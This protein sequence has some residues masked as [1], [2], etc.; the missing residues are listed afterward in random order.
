MYLSKFNLQRLKKKKMM[1]LRYFNYFLS[2][3][4]LLFSAVWLD[5]ALANNDSDTAPSAKSQPLKVGV[6][7]SPPFV[8]RNGDN[9]TGM[10]IELWEVLASHFGL[11]S[12]Y[13]EYDTVS[14]LIN[15]THNHEVD[16]AI[17]NLTITKARAKRIDFT[18][19][20]FDSGL[21]IMTNQDQR[22]GFTQLFRGLVDSG[23][24]RVYLFLAVI[25]FLFSLLLTLF[26]R[27]FDKDFPPQ[28]RD[29]FA[30][31]FYTVMS[32]ATSGN[33]PSRKNLFGWFGRIL[34]GLW[35]VC[36][37]AVLAYVTS[38]ITS[39]MTTLSLDNQINNVFDLGNHR[40][41]VFSGSVAESYALE[42]G[43]NAIPYAHI[44][45]AATA[46]Q[47]HEIR[48]IIADA[49]VLEYYAKT[50]PS[51]DV[52]VIGPLFELD[53]YGFG[54]NYDSPL[55]RPLTI[56]V[57]GAIEAGKIADIRK[58]YFGQTP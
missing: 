56:E 35:L 31:S 16:I 8:M 32:V 44:D 22:M 5:P 28:W 53:K 23:H 20:W 10:A 57:I 36:G 50:H 48:A 45:E 40:V 49:P 6:H 34:Q 11:Q 26:D 46:L 17:T 39:V 51:A 25:I 3:F 14:E 24:I 54:L 7:I 4:V 27:R 29:G 52:V 43:L 58:K 37:V 42:H 18:H 21:R 47:T 38:S 13:K 12:E 9:Y 15:A 30:E 2:A 33:S 55:T 19:P 1:I 41:G